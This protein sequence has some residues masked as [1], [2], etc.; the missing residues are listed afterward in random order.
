MLSKNKLYESDIV[1][2]ENVIEKLSDLKNETSTIALAKL[3]TSNSDSIR[4]FSDEFR[5]NL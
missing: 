5:E 2:I 4:P 3:W 1:G